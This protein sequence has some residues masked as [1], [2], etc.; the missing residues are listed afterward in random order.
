VEI[1]VTLRETYVKAKPG[2]SI[3]GD[4]ADISN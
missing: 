2:C 1:F 3:H 4:E